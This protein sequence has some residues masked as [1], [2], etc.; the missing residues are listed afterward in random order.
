MVGVTSTTGAAFI[1]L[2]CMMPL[3]TLYIMSKVKNSVKYN[4]RMFL[5]M[6]SMATQAASYG[7]NDAKIWRKTRIGYVNPVKRGTLHPIE[8]S[9]GRSTSCYM[10]TFHHIIGKLRIFY[11]LLSGAV[12][13]VIWTSG[14]FIFQMLT[15]DT[16]QF[17]KWLYNRV[18]F[19]IV[20]SV[21]VWAEAMF[22]NPVVQL[23]GQDCSSSWF[24]AIFYNLCFFA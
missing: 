9:E 4:L 11:T 20:F 8:F 24:T 19:E 15:R 3:Q 12:G 1:F 6:V 2:L 16:E 13:V 7:V 21:C 18:V 5:Q 22:M 10:C 17:D 14:C 23:I